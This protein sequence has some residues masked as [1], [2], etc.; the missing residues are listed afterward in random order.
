MMVDDI[1]NE[2][3]VD[4][5]LSQSILERMRK[6]TKDVERTPHRQLADFMASSA[7]MLNVQRKHIMEAESNY[8]IERIKLLDSYR[9]QIENLKHDCAEAVRALDEKHREDIADAQTLLDRLATMRG[10][11]L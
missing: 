10:M 7:R 4:D 2:P 11:T 5:G 9:V 1:Q 3:V 6:A 8:Q